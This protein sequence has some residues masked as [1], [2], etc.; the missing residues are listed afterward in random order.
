MMEYLVGI[1]VGTSSCSV[2]LMVDGVPR[3]L[4]VFDGQDEMPTYV[5]FAADGARLI[6]WPAKRQ[7][8]TNPT[9][10]IF[11]VKRL[12][13]RKGADDGTSSELGLLPYRVI[14]SATGTL[15]IEAAGRL[16]TPTEITAI[17]LGE[18]K[19]AAEAYLGGPVTQAVLTVPARFNRAQIRAT[20]DAAEIAGI[21]VVR[22]IAEPVAAALAYGFAN[23]QLEG[24]VAVY[25]LGGGT[26][27]VS[28]LALGD[29]VYEVKS[30]DG[31]NRLGGE[32]FD[33]ALVGYFV[34]QIR[35]DHGVDL[36]S[37]ALALHRI[38]DAAERI[39]I[40]LDSVE[41]VRAPLPYLTTDQGKM[42]NAELRIARAEIEDLFAGLIAQTVRPCEAAIRAASS[43]KHDD[44]PTPFKIDRLIL[45]GGMS[46]MPAIRKQ[47]A[48]LFGL[49]PSQQLDPSR[50]VALGAAILAGVLAGNV[51]DQLLLD[52]NRLPQCLEL[53]DGR[54]I[55]VIRANVTVPTKSCLVLGIDDPE[56]DV[57]F[58]AQEWSIFSERRECRIVE[59]GIDDPG[60]RLTLF[61]GP[62]DLPSATSTTGP[63]VEIILHIDANFKPSLTI[64]QLSDRK[65]L[66]NEPLQ[67]S[68]PY[69]ESRR[70]T[71]QG[72]AEARAQ[73]DDLLN[74][75][76]ALVAAERGIA[77]STLATLGEARVELERAMQSRDLSALTLAIAELSS[78][79][80]LTAEKRSEELP[81]PVEIKAEL[82]MKATVFI[83]YARA[84]HRW[85]D[86]LLIHL[87]PLVR[88]QSVT[89]WHDGKIEPGDA[90]KRDIDDA[91]ARSSI[92]V[93]LISANFVASDFIYANELPPMLERHRRGGLKIIP[94]VVSNSQFEVDPVLSGLG[95]F[96]DPKLPLSRMRKPA[97]EAELA[98]LARAI[99]EDYR[100]TAQFAPA[101][102][103][104]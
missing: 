71:E 39:K 81:A 30:V 100:R 36:S 42:F 95:A 54:L 8:I 28:I 25:D 51:R 3:V 83:S 13:G 12:I 6:G 88:E 85:L 79:S 31:D 101:S 47:V 91:L 66:V 58:S 69:G 44:D 98:R 103:N 43:Y 38:K 57:S 5:A 53:P 7:A 72:L 93:L 21:E 17:M 65:V 97:A 86:R 94:V 87:K 45:V 90:W 96:N 50:I 26:F 52:V 92:A 2:S 73:A 62:V 1:D 10:T 18:V 48:E 63:V 46:R 104:G 40:D 89:V 15:W 59:G 49:T 75:V 9:N 35:R 67:V 74:A 78:R 84:D 80:H 99:W 76:D 20:V 77:P 56:C 82:A 55:N 37:N 68:N 32:D 22:T 29:G 11:T 16:F 41:T 33:H 102:T 70:S 64:L 61:D 27:D 24:G 23:G 4:P 60:D 14:T 19:R 34:D